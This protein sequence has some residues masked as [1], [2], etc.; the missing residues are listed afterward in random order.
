MTRRGRL[1]AVAALT[2]LLG[3]AVAETAKTPVAAARVEARAADLLAVG[4]VQDGRMIVHLSRPL[5]NAPIPDA[6]LTVRLRGAGHLATVE[7]DGSYSVATPDLALQGTAV[8]LFEV[9]RPGGGREDL[10]GTLEIA[11]G[12]VQPKDKNSARQLAWWVLN[13]AVCI[14]FLLLWSKRRKLRDAAGD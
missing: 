13:F 9:V 1:S 2:L 4:I 3:A 12:T 14:G 6:A 8:V 5:D 10:H 7:A 11:G